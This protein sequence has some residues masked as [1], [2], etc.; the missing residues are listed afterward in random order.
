MVTILAIDGGG[1]RGLLPARMLQEIQFRLRAA[2]DR[3]PLA[4]HFDLI[5]GTSTGALIALR[6]ALLDRDG[7]E[8]YS[9]ADIVDLYVRRG[10]EIFPPRL[11]TTHKAI[12]AFR[13][14]YAGAGLEGLLAD[15]FG[16]ASLNSAATNLLITSFDTEAMEPHCMR[17]G[18]S[19]AT[20][21]NHLDYYM[22]DA[23]RASAAAPTFF[24]PARVSPIGFPH[25]RL[26]LIDGA[27]F[28]NNPSG[29]AYVESTKIFPSEDDILILSLGTGKERR[30][31]CYDEIHSWGYVEWINPVRGFPLGAIVSAAQSETVNHQLSRIRGV[32]YLRIDTPLRDCDSPID[33]SSGR[34]LDCLNRLAD[35]MLEENDGRIDEVLKTLISKRVPLESVEPLAIF[36][37]GGR[38]QVLT[39]VS[40]I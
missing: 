28:A 38:S 9:A 25:I 26:S 3:N 14:K 31:F 35:E 1:I 16:D 17:G 2:G 18:P 33:D 20:W 36:E 34:N 32:R 23:A 19:R 12:Q 39:G 27:V 22:R 29:L 6:T 10:K 15:L 8:P 40:P 13:Y 37:P 30:G 4:L 11:R 7:A 21:A 5:A 24:P